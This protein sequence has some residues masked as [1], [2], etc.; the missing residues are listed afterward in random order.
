MKEADYDDFQDLGDKYG[1]KRE[2]YTALRDKYGDTY[3]FYY[4]Y[5][6]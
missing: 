6:R 4:H 3:W 1:N 5:K 2:R